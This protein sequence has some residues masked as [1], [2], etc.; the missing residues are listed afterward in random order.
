MSHMNEASYTC[1]NNVTQLNEPR[2][3]D[4]WCND[5]VCRSH[6]HYIHVAAMWVAA[7]IR[8]KTLNLVVGR[9]NHQSVY[10]ICRCNTESSLHRQ[11]QW[12]LWLHLPTTRFSVLQQMQM[13]PSSFHLYNDH[14]TLNL[15]VG[16]CNHQSTD[17]VRHSEC[18][19]MS[20]LQWVCC[21]QSP[22]YR[23]SDH[24]T[25]VITISRQLM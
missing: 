11:M 12:S 22:V 23:C 15:V 10:R 13:Q 1:I 18:V 14:C 20:V 2:F 7:T 16:R 9:S 8:C 25:D 4:S 6:C 3:H 24:C 5:N 17:A 21:S 19:A